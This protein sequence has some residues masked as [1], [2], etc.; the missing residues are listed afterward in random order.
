MREDR[1]EFANT[2][3]GIAALCVMV[4]HMI[5]FWGEP[6]FVA[7]TINADAIVPPVEM[8]SALWFV[9]HNL[10]AIGLD[11]G[12]FGVGIFFVISGFVISISLAKT[13]VGEFAVRR[14]F[15]LWPTYLTCFAIMLLSINATGWYF[16][17]AFPFDEFSLL[18]H[19]WPG[20]NETFGVPYLDGISWSLSVELKFYIFAALCAGLLRRA[21]LK[22]FAIAVAV[23]VGPYLLWHF[24]P[25]RNDLGLF[26][27]R[28]L[29]SLVFFGDFLLILM[30][31]VAF[32]FHHA[33]KIGNKTF[34]AIVSAMLSI[35]VAMNLLSDPAI[36]SPRY[37]VWS[38]VAAVAVFWACYLLR[39]HFRATVPTTFL[40]N[41]SYPLYALHC[42]A[43]W[44]FM[45]MLWEVGLSS[46]T[47]AILY[48]VACFAVCWLIHRAIEAPANR[49]GGELARKLRLKPYYPAAAGTAAA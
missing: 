43:G 11:L 18:I 37:V 24:Y 2:L 14:F 9:G 35:F 40:A 13:S 44:C 28:T 12:S 8:P 25:N 33:R 39:D 3:R 46:N 47:I 32:Q 42:Y 17:R 7:Q 31:G 36:L 5:G 48:I 21:D 19:L 1:V 23:S 45:R 29:W 4:T 41:I 16:G 34:C 26:G 20:L 6:A 15:R 27:V 38:Y 22:V 10:H 49:L 30:V